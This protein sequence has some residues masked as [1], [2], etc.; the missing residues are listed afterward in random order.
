MNQSDLLPKKLIIFAVLISMA[1]LVAILTLTIKMSSQFESINKVHLPLLEMN[2]INVR[3]GDSLTSKSKYLIYDY[4]LS[5]LEDYQKDKDSLMFNFKN[6]IYT[7]DSSNIQYEFIKDFRRDELFSLESEVINLA[8][9]GKK[10][11]ALS[12][13]SSSN[14][15]SAQL[16]F[17]N[18]IQS[19][20]EKLSSKRDEFLTEQVRSV[21]IGVIFSAITFVLI[22]MVWMK[23]YIS[24]KKNSKERAIALKELDL[25]KVKSSHNSKMASLGEM[26]AGLA[27]E[28]NNPLTIIQGFSGKLMKSI[29]RNELDE[30]KIEHY[31]ERIYSTSKRIDK[32]V[33]G[34][35]VFS[36][37]SG[38]ADM[39][40]TNVEDI[41]NDTL[42]FCSERFKSSGIDLN[43]VFDG[44]ESVYIN[45]RSVEIS[46]VLLNLLN[47]AFDELERSDLI[48]S[49][50][51]IETK[52][53]DEFVYISVEDSGL[54]INDELKKKIF[55][56]FFTTKDGAHGTGLGL[57]ISASIVKNHK[58]QIYLDNSVTTEFIIKLPR[59]NIKLG[60]SAA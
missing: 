60:S 26:A 52:Q 35:K 45:A 53:D 59:P 37:N 12:I 18:I 54:G 31:A 38:E 7:L 39:T 21:Q 15:K 19:V 16:E 29:E 27:H 25:E 24:Y 32:M 17:N 40:L 36:K 58:G 55:D 46:Q 42:S 9:Q 20:A 2:A 4:N 14:Y 50:I 8:K 34:L 13:L 1:Y 33:Q 10:D 56:P 48:H 5:S 51:K 28:I 44:K 47:N 3:L 57:S 6:Y 11:E 41:V 23:V 22:T 43:V 30:D 49:W